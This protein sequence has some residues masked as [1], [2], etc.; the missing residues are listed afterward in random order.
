MKERRIYSPHDTQNTPFLVEEQPHYYSYLT[1]RHAAYV[2]D[3]LEKRLADSYTASTALLPIGEALRN[4]RSHRKKMI[5]GWIYAELAL[6]ADNFST[7]ERLDF[8]NTGVQCWNLAHRAFTRHDTQ[9][10]RH[11][12]INRDVLPSIRTLRCRL[13]LATSGI[14]AAIASGDATKESRDLL[15]ENMLTVATQADT[16]LVNMQQHADL[17][18]HASSYRGF[19]HEINAMLVINRL[20]STS[21]IA[22]PSLPRSDSG[23]GERN[24]THDIQVLNTRWGQ[25]RN[26]QP[27]EVK[28]DP[29]EEHY[30]RYTAAIV[31]GTVHLHTEHDRDPSHLTELLVKEQLGK[32][33]EE[34]QMQLDRITNRVVHAI[35][36]GYNGTEQC[37]DVTQCSLYGLERNNH[38]EHTT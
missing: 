18:R 28:S 38:K 11:H 32:I 24:L 34:E 16:A 35:R 2:Y 22:L 7:D 4:Q 17:E 27:I 37:R 20:R 9:T 15:Q 29:Q 30:E 25:I 23:V 12:N 13:S 31:G 6:A 14:I 21:L 36:H 3:Q 8:L 19:L 26:V 1:P 5:T 10:A 33:N